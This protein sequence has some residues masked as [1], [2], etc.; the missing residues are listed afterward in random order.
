MFRAARLHLGLQS[1]VLPLVLNVS[2]REGGDR[3]EKRHPRRAPVAA[4]NRRL[5][6]RLESEQGSVG[7]LSVVCT[8]AA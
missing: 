4:D 3:I 8:H 5:I 7:A 6:D 2:K 1:L